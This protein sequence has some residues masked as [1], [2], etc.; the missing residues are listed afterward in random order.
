MNLDLTYS[1]L[2][3]FLLCVMAGQPTVSSE[4]RSFFYMLWSKIQ[5]GGPARFM[6]LPSIQEICPYWTPDRHA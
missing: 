3:H 4:L 5:H 2:K 1:S 6:K